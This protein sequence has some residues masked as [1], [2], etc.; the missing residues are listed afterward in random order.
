MRTI[1]RIQVCIPNAIFRCMF[2]LLMVFLFYYC[3]YIC[4]LGKTVASSTFLG[5]SL[6]SAWRHRTY[7][8]PVVSVLLNNS[9]WPWV[10]R[11]FL[12]SSW[13]TSATV[14]HLRFFGS[15]ASGRTVARTRCGVSFS[16]GKVT[17]WPG[18]AARV[19]YSLL[20]SIYKLPLPS[21]SF[22]LRALTCCCSCVLVEL[23]SYYWV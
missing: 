20:V 7:C 18:C 22:S 9:E 16:F 14:R 23:N 6:I 8:K 11:V 12:T 17:L 3:P 21:W 4:L 13:P 10:S 19:M 1:P 5:S 15:A 2:T